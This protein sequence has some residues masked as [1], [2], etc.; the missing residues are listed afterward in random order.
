MNN[1]TELPEVINTQEDMPMVRS[2]SSVEVQKARA[3]HE[4]QAAFVIA[5]KFPRDEFDAEKR[6]AT[7][8]KRIGLAE[9]AVYAFPRGKEKVTGPSIRLAEAVA[10]AW[11]NIKYGFEEIEQVEGRSIV[12]AF[13]HDYETNTHVSRKFM[14][15]HKIM[16]KGGKEKKL[17]DP[18]DIYELIANHAQRRVRATIIE[19][20]PGEVMDKAVELCKKTLASGGKNEPIV[21]RV[22]KM[23]VAFGDIGVSKDLIEKRLGHGADL[24]TVEEIADLVQIYNSLKDGMT[25]RHEWF[26]MSSPSD[27]GKA[28]ELNKKILEQDKKPS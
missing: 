24:I 1:E 10:R 11:G 9:S 5:K 20:I 8:C 26:D 7:A 6:I 14:V 4:V 17:V 19:V 12:E 22:K 21:D 15:Y 2:S 25:Q 28:E 18:R 3:A 16:L 13:C 27:G 23:V